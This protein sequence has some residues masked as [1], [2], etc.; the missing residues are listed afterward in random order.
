MS[1]EV[2]F[3]L[4][5]SKQFEYVHF[6]VTAETVEG[7]NENL[8]TVSDILMAKISD[9]HRASADILTGKR[10]VPSTKPFDIADSNQLAEVFKGMPH[11]M[12]PN[13]T[14]SA[15]ELITQEL[16]GK[17]IEVEQKPWE[18]PAPAVVDFF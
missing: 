6:K 18:R 10:P 8:D 13:D 1:F 17:V 7:L 4:P 15:E 14:R 12:S 5:G 11:V 2:E 3:G 9:I 16:D